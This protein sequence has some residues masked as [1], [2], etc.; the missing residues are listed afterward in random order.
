MNSR[1]TQMGTLGIVNTGA[2]LSVS[3][4]AVERV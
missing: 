4:S 3:V 2:A 1:R